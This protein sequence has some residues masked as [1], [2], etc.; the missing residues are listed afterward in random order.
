[1]RRNTMAAAVA[2]VA[3]VFAAAGGGA[4]A[5]QPIAPLGASPHAAA[6]QVQYYYPDWQGPRGFPG[7]FEERRWHRRQQRRA[8]EEE[9]IAEAAR[10]EAW[11]IERER[12]ERRAWRHAQRERYWHHQGF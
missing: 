11:R 8:Y 2:T 5:A 9:R 12:A 7:D 10:R 4:L 3:A 6:E 1:M